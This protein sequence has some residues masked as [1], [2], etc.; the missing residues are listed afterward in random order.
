MEIIYILVHFFAT[1]FIFNLYSQQ[2]AHIMRIC[3][4]YKMNIEC[5]QRVWVIMVNTIQNIINNITILHIKHLTGLYQAKQRK[6]KRSKVDFG[7]KTL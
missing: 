3:K 5:L 1:T 2:P 4:K 7:V 6:E